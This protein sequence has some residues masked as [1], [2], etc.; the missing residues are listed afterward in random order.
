MMAFEGPFLASI[1]ARMPEAKYNLAAYGV[2]YSIA[3][4]LE[5]PVIMMMAASTT[6]VKNE[7]SFLK[8][9]RFNNLLIMLVTI[10]ALVI[11]I[12]PVFDFIA[13]SII[14]LP[15]EVAELTH[16]S[17]IF[18]LP[19]PAAIAYR[20]FLQGILIANNKTRY[21]SY[22]TVI[23][24]LSMSF[25]ALISYKFFELPGAWL[26]ACALSAGVV[27][28]MIVS[29]LMCRNLIK[30]IKDK[31]RQPLKADYKLRYKEIYRF[32]YPLVL[33]SFLAFAAHPMISLFLG[34]SKMAIES[35]AV[36][37]V[38]NALVFIFRSIGLSF[39]EVVIILLGE[40]NEGYASLKKFAF[41]LGLFN[42]VIL[43]TI[44]FS[45]FHHIWFENISGLPEQLSRIAIL[46]TQILV[47][48]PALSVLLA[49]QRAIQVAFKKTKQ[50]TIATF[51]EVT[52]IAGVIS[53]CISW[54]DIIGITSAAI[55]LLLGRLGS[56]TFLAF[57]NYKILKVRNAK[58]VDK[59]MI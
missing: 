46:P 22:G 41:K 52:L 21:V 57:Q 55:A 51:I 32:Y 58:F 12:P 53:I 29:H 31:N 5:A 3:L 13:L 30:S 43:G 28:E 18:L 54:L 17:L 27:M 37:P 47:I 49:F 59:E 38:I 34:N 39:Q 48:V 19:W 1:I 42:L 50:I 9:R 40:K 23:R 25:S 11:L 26:G 56:N 45:P 7:T 8:L 35:L 6:L 14:N 33:S 4:L 15:F 24:L 10:S 20:R 44:A 36:L 16:T 2:A